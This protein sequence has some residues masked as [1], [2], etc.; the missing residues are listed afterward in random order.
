MT[1]QIGK[2]LFEILERKNRN[3]KFNSWRNDD[4]RRRI[5]NDTDSECGYRV[6]SINDD[7]RDRGTDSFRK[8]ERQCLT[9]K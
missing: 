1:A 9:L 7:V 4:S 3:E 2:V 6:D 5:F 8:G